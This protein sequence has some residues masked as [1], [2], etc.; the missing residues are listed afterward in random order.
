M[1]EDLTSAVAKLVE[2]RDAIGFDVK[3]N[4]GDPGVIFVAG[5]ETPMQV[6]NDDGSAETV[7]KIS[8]E[9]LADLLSGE[10]SAMNA[11]MQGKL[12]VEGDLGRAMQLSTLFS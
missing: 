2:G 11:Y 4:L 8:E 1:L 10:L 3:F 12:K 6:N 7:F 9:Y 5:T